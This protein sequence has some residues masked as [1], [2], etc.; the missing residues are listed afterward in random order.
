MAG[1]RGQPGGPVGGPAGGPA[2]PAQQPVSHERA[3][4]RRRDDDIAFELPGAVL[5][6]PE[7]LDDPEV[8][9]ALGELEGDVLSTLFV[10]R[11]IIEGHAAATHGPT[12]G[13]PNAMSGP[14]IGG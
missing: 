10:L 5:D 4:S 6:F 11:R 8:A 9:P 14:G 2:R 3:R 12:Y 7:L 1:A 13:H